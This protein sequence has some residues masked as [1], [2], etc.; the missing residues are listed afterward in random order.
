MRWRNDPLLYVREGFRDPDTG[1]ELQLAPWSEELFGLIK[2]HDRVSVRAARGVGKTAG[3]VAVSYWRL[4]CFKN[5][6]NIFTAPRREQMTLASW[7]EMRKWHRAMVPDLRRMFEIQTNKVVMTGSE[8]NESV[9]TTV[10]SGNYEALQGIHES[11]LTFFADEANGVEDAVFDVILGSSTGKKSKILL[12]GNPRKS[13]GLFFRTHT[14]R[15]LKD[16]WRTLHVSAFD[17]KDMPYY[18][19]DWIEEMRETW[20]ENSWQWQCYVL[21]NFPE[22]DGTGVI[23]AAL[24]MDAAQRQVLRVDGHNPIWGFDPAFGGGDRCALAK[25]QGNIVDSVETWSYRDTTLSRDRLVDDYFSTAVKP[26]AICIDATGG[27][28]HMANDLARLGLPIIQVQAS[29]RALRSEIYVNRRA[30]MW[31][32]GRKFFEGRD[33]RIPDDDELVE[34]LA[35]VNK[36]LTSANNQS[37]TA[38]EYVEGKDDVRTRIGRS[39]DKADALLLTLCCP[40]REHD[41]GYLKREIE[42]RHGK[43]NMAKKGTSWV[44]QIHLH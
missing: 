40:A 7:S 17:V 3:I 35:A 19:S 41:K 15:K 29:Q 18:S 26:V 36:G 38:K 8:G 1:G 25:R 22:E 2:D 10:G 28:I 6:R 14:S 5:S 39:T 20:G 31:Y 13:A 42:A 27:G 30:E 34:E 12:T 11:H 33:V 9:A 23:P 32:S 24:I 37:T 16:R 44:S 43:F 21:G 4:T